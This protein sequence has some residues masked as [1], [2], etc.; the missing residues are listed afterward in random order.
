MS[1]NILRRTA[2]ATIRTTS[3]LAYRCL[4]AQSCCDHTDKQSS[5][6]TRPCACMHAS[7]ASHESP[8]ILW[9]S[10]T[11]GFSQA[12]RRVRSLLRRWSL[13]A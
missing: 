8:C 7:A 6:R 10:R 2:L 1:R 12:C 9:H 13:S 5:A 4:R 11:W 3:A